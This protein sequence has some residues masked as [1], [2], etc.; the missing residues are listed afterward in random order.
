MNGVA[1]SLTESRDSGGE[2][3]TLTV[4]LSLSHYRG[5]AAAQI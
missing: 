2:G 1:E 3:T 5:R 4:G